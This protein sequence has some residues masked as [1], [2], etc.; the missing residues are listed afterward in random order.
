MS[1]VK[2]LAS[3]RRVLRGVMGGSMISVGLPLLD[4]FLDSK[5]TAF[6]ATGESL[7]PVFGTWFWGCGLTPGLW[8]PAKVGKDYDIKHLLK[9]LTPFKDEMT[10]FSGM[11]TMLDGKP[12]VPHTSGAL[13]ALSGNA[14]Q[15]VTSLDV[16][17]ADQIGATTRFRS[18][19]VACTGVASAGY[20]RRSATV[21][22]PSEVSPLGLYT[23]IFGPE[24]TD[25][26]AAE[27]KPD[28]RFMVRRSVLSAI[29]D[30][31]KEMMK[32]LGASDRA[33]LDEYFISLR[34]VEQQLEIQLRKPAP[35]AAC[36]IP[37]K[38]DERKPNFDIE[39]AIFNH[40]IMAK[41]LAHAAACDQTRVFNVAFSIGASDLKSAQDAENHH[42]LTHEELIDTKLGYQPK[43]VRFYEQQMAAFAQM[44]QAL[45][46]V[47]EG[48]GTLLDRALVYATSEGGEARVHSLDNMPM[49]LVGRAGGRVKGG[50]HVA[51]P[52][53]PV[54][55]VGL[56]IQQALGVPTT[57][58]GFGSMR[59]SKAITDL[60]A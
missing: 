47:K 40:G 1:V 32:S 18:L 53:E 45:R 27:F 15:L 25:P 49:M 51:L 35:L 54:T 8:E 42:Q 58:W 9:D 4:C 46:D 7:P 52:G 44:L 3:R 6:A 43:V 41:L 13:A 29:T 10:V 39:T 57:T 50:Y 11:T 34:Q 23:R 60:L 30:Q 31:R 37:A 22:N 24:F 36:S 48:D 17:V 33:R 16:L 20:S 2:S 12:L 28:P 55:R 26:N 59:T 5:G 38:S 56:T 21:A 14:T 19:E